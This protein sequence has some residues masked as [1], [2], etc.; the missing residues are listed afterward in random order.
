MAT[1]LLALNKLRRY[2][3]KSQMLQSKLHPNHVN[4]FTQKEPTCKI[5]AL[6]SNDTFS[7]EN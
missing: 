3:K 1:I 4:K 6:N 5:R 7:S 2:A